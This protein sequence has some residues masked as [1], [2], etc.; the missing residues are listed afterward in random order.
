MCTRP[1][2]VVLCAGLA[3][4]CAALAANNPEVE[5]NDSKLLANAFTLAPGDSVS[6]QSL[7]NSTVVPGAASA[8]TFLIR[9]AATSQGIYRYTMTLTSPGTLLHT[10]SLRGLS[11]ALGIVLPLSDVTAQPSLAPGDNTRQNVWYGFGHQ[12]QVYYRVGGT[13]S[14]T[15]VVYTATLTRDAVTP[16]PLGVTPASGPLTFLVTMTGSSSDPD[17]WVYNADTMAA[18][19]NFGNDD[20]PGLDGGS[21]STLTRAFAPGHYLLAVTDYNLMNNQPAPGDDGSTSAPVM[22][23]PDIA[24]ASDQEGPWTATVEVHR[25]DVTGTLVG[26]GAGSQ[27]QSFEI[28][29]LA[30]DVTNGCPADLGMQGG[31]AGPDGM[32]DNNDFV[33]FINYFFGADPH[34]DI[35]QQGGLPGGDGHFDNNDFVV[36][37]NDFFAGCSG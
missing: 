5:P 11:Q 8:D 2:K 30:F 10:A 4:G 36:F 33:V 31:L 15:G 12:E 25:G 6:G 19:A 27:S 32:L 24:A 16:T 3:V 26:T 7:G 34:A 14:S 37:I 17:I 29:W 9:T 18:I 28:L 20:T 22:D 21:F 23:F 35:G 13:L 1:K